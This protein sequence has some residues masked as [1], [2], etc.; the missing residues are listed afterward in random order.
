MYLSAVFDFVL[1]F[2]LFHSTFDHNPEAGFVSFK[3]AGDHFVKTKPEEI[4]DRAG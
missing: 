3:R 1:V 2:Q 4:R